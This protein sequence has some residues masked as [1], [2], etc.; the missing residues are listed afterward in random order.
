MFTHDQL[1]FSIVKRHPDA[2]HGV[3]FW[4]AQPVAGTQQLANAHIVQWS[5]EAPQ[6]D[7]KDIPLM[8]LADLREWN[9]AVAATAAN[10]EL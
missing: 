10:S 4:V 9:A 3:D 7:P 2:R 1:I 6:P 5:I 8:V